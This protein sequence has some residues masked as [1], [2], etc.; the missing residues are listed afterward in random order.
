MKTKKVVV[1]RI[2]YPLKHLYIMAL[3][4][5]LALLSQQK[6]VF[7]GNSDEHRIMSTHIPGMSWLQPDAEAL[8]NDLIGLL[9]TDVSVIIENDLNELID[10]AQKYAK[11]MEKIH[12]KVVAQV[13]NT[14]SLT[15]NQFRFVAD[16][17]HRHHEANL[18]L[19]GLGGGHRQKHHS[20]RGRS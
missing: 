11:R 5:E 8:I 13:K 19:A 14:P 20:H 15:T 6:A 12:N 4:E 7:L 16:H 18:R 17:L 1:V 3:A 9:G 2:A 10:C